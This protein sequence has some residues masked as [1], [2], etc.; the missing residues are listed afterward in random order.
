MTELDRFI[1][2][3]KSGTLG[4]KVLAQLFFDLVSGGEDESISDEM[5]EIAQKPGHAGGYAGCVLDLVRNHLGNEW[6]DENDDM[7][8]EFVDHVSEMTGPG[9]DESGLEATYEL[10]R[11]EIQRVL[12]EEELGK[13]TLHRV[14]EMAKAMS[15]FLENAAPRAIYTD[16][17][18]ENL[19]RLEKLM[20]TGPGD[21]ESVP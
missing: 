3:A 12:M 17:A 13:E 2:T 19:A 5:N 4:P 20:G 1:E 21:D 15:I 6:M 10:M 14:S 18:A 7:I 9:I 8:Q 16:R 11:R